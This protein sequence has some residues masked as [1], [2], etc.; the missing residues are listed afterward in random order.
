MTFRSSTK[1]N[2]QM[3]ENNDQAMYGGGHK[4]Y[5]FGKAQPWIPTEAVEVQMT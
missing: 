3:C 4:L 5:I 1:S 2:I